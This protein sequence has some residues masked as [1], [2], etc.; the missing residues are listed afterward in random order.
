LVVIPD[1]VTSY[2]FSGS[3]LT[4]RGTNVYKSIVFISALLHTTVM[5]SRKKPASSVDLAVKY[6]KKPAHYFHIASRILDEQRELQGLDPFVISLSGIEGAIVVACDAAQML[7][8][9]GW[10]I[11]HIETKRVEVESRYDTR[12]IA[13]SKMTIHLTAPS[14]YISVSS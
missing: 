13:R 5:S 1:S 8:K 9:A 11:R 14:S 2:A 12:E 4:V 10:A 6:S 3:G 7:V